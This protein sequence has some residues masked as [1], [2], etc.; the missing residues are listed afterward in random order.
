MAARLR[1]DG[2]QP[3]RRPPARNP[4]DREIQIAA[5]AIGL[6]ERQ[7]DEGTVSAQVLSH[8]VKFASR[9]AELQRE[10]LRR[11]NELLKAKV[12]GMAS[13]QRLESL[14][15]DAIKAM[16]SYSGEDEEDAPFD[17]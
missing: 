10:K 13:T 8:Y 3:R 11:E 1:S 5:K 12:D 17:D 14:Y 6:V 9:E 4:E 15:E 2:P 16:R 7:I